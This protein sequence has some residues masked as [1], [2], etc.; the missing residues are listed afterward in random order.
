MSGFFLSFQR[1]IVEFAVEDARIMRAR[2]QRK[3][4]SESKKGVIG[5][6]ILEHREEGHKGVRGK[7]VRGTNKRV[8]WQL[9]CKEKRL[10]RRERRGGHS[11]NGDEQNRNVKKINRGGGIGRKR[12]DPSDV[13][14]VESVAGA[15]DDVKRRKRSDVSVDGVRKHQ[16]IKPSK[17]QSRRVSV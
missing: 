7:G 6:Q 5:G 15:G 4:R 11:D 10:R 14:S 8:E 9:K 2:E 12:R 16:K 17:R 13:P 1:L 3:K